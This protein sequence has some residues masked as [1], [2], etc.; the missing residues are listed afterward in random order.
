VNSIEKVIEEKTFR[1]DKLID[2]E[3][4]VPCKNFDDFFSVDSNKSVLSMVQWWNSP[5][6]I[7][8]SNDDLIWDGLITNISRDHNSKTARVESR[9]VLWKYMNKNLSYTSSDWETPGDAVKNILVQEGITDYLATELNKSIGYYELNSVSVKCFFYPEDNITVF[10]ALEKLAEIGFADCYSRKGK[11]CFVAWQPFTGYIAKSLTIDDI[12]SGGV[13]VA[14]APKDVINDYSIHY[15]NDGD[16]AASDAANNNIGAASRSIFG[17]QSLPAIDGGWESQVVIK[18]KATAVFIGEQYIK[19]TQRNINKDG[20]QVPQPLQEISFTLSFNHRQWISIETYFK[21]TL[22][23]ENW[24][25]K[26]FEVFRVEIDE[27]AKNIRV[28]AYEVVE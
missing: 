14:F 8:N 19:R 6:K 21:M 13:Q 11:I 22:A 2:N 25:D 20:N 26:K 18:D 27:T 3:I 28:K 9:S 10:Q 5:L 4:S 12:Y 23:S 7:Y 15:A 17:T 1:K 16:V 24:T